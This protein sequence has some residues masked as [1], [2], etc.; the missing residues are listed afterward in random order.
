M[1]V[2]WRA[3]CGRSRRCGGCCCRT[4]S[5]VW[6]DL[7]P[8]AAS[9]RGSSRASRR[10]SAGARRGSPSSR[11]LARRPDT[12]GGRR[13]HWTHKRRAYRRGMQRGALR[14]AVRFG[15]GI[16]ADAVFTPLRG[17]AW[18]V[19]APRSAFSEKVMPPQSHQPHGR[20]WPRLAVPRGVSAVAAFLAPVL[21]GLVSAAQ[22]RRRCTGPAGIL[23]RARKA[24][25]T[26]CQRA[27]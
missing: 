23:G 18:R 26:A 27:R 13:L 24:D 21:V 15:R 2:V 22:L 10:T 8:C 3:S 5:R 19:A 11:R 9:A 20:G 7:Q 1:G 16:G 12:A 4:S 17:F 14:W 6:P 25:R